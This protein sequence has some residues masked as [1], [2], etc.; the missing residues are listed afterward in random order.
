MEDSKSV[1]DVRLVD[2][3]KRLTEVQAQSALIGAKKIAKGMQ[4]ETTKQ[5]TGLR[6][7]IKEQADMYGQ[8]KEDIESVVEHYNEVLS[9][10]RIAY[11]EERDAIIEEK[12]DHE[13]E[14]HEAVAEYEG[15]KEEFF[16]MR[17]Q[18]EYQ[19]TEVAK[20][21][22]EIA[23]LRKDGRRQ[24]ATAKSKELEDYKNGLGKEKKFLETKINMLMSSDDPSR[25]SQ[26]NEISQKL[27]AIQKEE[28]IANKHTNV[29][30]AKETLRMAREETKRLDKELENCKEEFKKQ[31]EEIL[32]DKETSLAKVDKQNVFQ[33]M[34]GKIANKI[35]GKKK[36]QE[37]VMNPIK[38]KIHTVEVAVI[39]KAANVEHK[40]KK[41]VET[42]KE[43]G[44]NVIQSII[45]NAKTKKKTISDNLKQKM[46]EKI[47]KDSQ[48]IENNRNNRLSEK[49]MNEKYD[50]YKKNGILTE[51]EKND[52][53]EI[54][55]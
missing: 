41:I 40:A 6:N 44:K 10:A 31:K 36:F 22:R 19:E 3:L 32:G 13:V 54:G 4:N 39:G 14:E 47:E 28:E 8:S 5:L 33:K 29:M 30:D 16:E 21:T 23:K 51:Q 18:P 43:T 26:I 48:Y 1:V 27:E 53:Q 12:N 46:L 49:Q 38:E 9:K 2:L 42:G 24:E 20:R 35:G 50:G 45:S 7:Y 15:T 25:Y 17:K 11:K 55:G 52:D 37:R 34:I